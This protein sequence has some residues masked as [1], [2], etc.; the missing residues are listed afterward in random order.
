MNGD[1]TDPTPAE[2][3]GA[4][5][6]APVGPEPTV[7]PLPGAQ[8]P[9]QE[10]V[11]P[12]APPAGAHADAHLAPPVGYAP[13]S[14][15]TP[16]V[17]EPD[18]PDQQ[19]PSDAVISPY[20][21]GTVPASGNYRVLTAVI[22]LFLLALLAGAIALIVY[23]AGHT[24]LSFPSADPEPRPVVT[25]VSE[26]QTPQ[27]PREETSPEP[28]TGALC[29]D[30]CVEV[31]GIVGPQIVGADG[32]STWAL[33]GAWSTVDTSPLS[34]EEAAGADYTSDAGELTFT[35]WRFAD[36]EAAQAAQEALVDSLGDPSDSGAAFQDGTGEQ[37]TFDD[38]SQT[39]IVWS[40]LGDGSQPWVMQVHG[41][42]AVQQFYYALPI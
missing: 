40:K 8:D 5:P 34:A 17:A 26:T 41:T 37:S 39:T 20:I 15:P 1:G 6:P 12:P 35:I 4:V 10:S 30:L 32:E 3:G 38:G 9:P 36:D 23:L 25:E 24:T 7:P 19:W 21:G 16:P 42:G 29:T 13:A 28:L 14:A 18:A 2:A 11:R 33:T 27:A 22:M 31:A